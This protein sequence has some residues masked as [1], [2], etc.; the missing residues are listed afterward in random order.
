[1]LLAYLCN[2]VMVAFIL[3]SELTLYNRTEL[4]LL[5]SSLQCYIMVLES[6]SGTSQ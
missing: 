3:D 1:M 2:V 6:I 4:W 5:T